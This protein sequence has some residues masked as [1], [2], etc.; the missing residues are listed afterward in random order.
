MLL[1]VV[2][3]SNQKR[4]DGLNACWLGLHSNR[5]PPKR[6]L[7][8]SCYRDPDKFEFSYTGGR[9]EVDEIYFHWLSLNWG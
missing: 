5:T 8:L 1:F 4:L 7:L 6:N 3:K 2:T 9:K